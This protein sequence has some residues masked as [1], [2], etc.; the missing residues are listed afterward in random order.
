MNYEKYIAPVVVALALSTG[1]KYGC[2][3]DEHDYSPHRAARHSGSSHQRQSRGHGSHSERSLEHSLTHEP[4]TEG[5][6]K[7]ARNLKPKWQGNYISP[8]GVHYIIVVP[9]VNYSKPARITP[10][11]RIRE[12]V[13]YPP[14]PRAGSEAPHTNAGGLE[15]LADDAEEAVEGLDSMVPCHGRGK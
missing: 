13:N 12:G 5:F 10:I 11:G 14:K 2:G 1:C 3:K 6:V 15:R 7:P 4:N 9:Q 8:Q